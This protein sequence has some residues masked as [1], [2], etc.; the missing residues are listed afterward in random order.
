MKKFNKDKYLKMLKFKKFINT[1]SKY[2]YI[3]I[4]TMICSC[5]GMYLTYSKFF[6]NQE[7]EVIRTTV[8]NF[9]QGDVV[10]AAYINGE[11]SNS[12]PGKTDG[13]YIDKITC[14]NGTTADWDYEKWAL[15]LTNLTKKTKCNLYLKT[16]VSKVPNIIATLDT[17]G[18]C[19]TVNDDGSV[20][21][22][23][24][25]ATNGY[26]C[27]AKDAYGDSYYFRG[28]VTNNYVK[29]A[30]FYWRIVRINGDET[31]RVIYDG[32]S[33]YANGQVN[34]S[35]QIGTSYFNSSYTDNAYVGYMYGQT[36][37]SNYTATHTNTNNSTVKIYIDNWYKSK[38]KDTTYEKFIADNTFCA[39]R[40]LAKNNSGTGGSK[41]TTY[42][43]GHNFTNSSH[44]IKIILTCPQKNDAFT[45]NDITH[46]NGA[47]TY[48][49]S[50]LSMDEITLAGAWDYLVSS[51]YLFS[52][53]EWW[54]LTPSDFINDG[55]DSGTASVWRVYR[56]GYVESRGTSNEN[57]IRPVINLKPE[58]LLYGSGT[59]TDP[60][61]LITESLT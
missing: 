1:Y 39:D 31:V 54:T 35:R 12:I 59:T 37:N 30:G 17:T 33:A 6:V 28:N 43:R 45:V 52:N 55:D 15:I 48:P 25:E 13:Y 56:N 7:A 46:G 19:P 10:I 41:S 53:S 22:T 18:K 51:N 57:G 11:Y 23:G 40:S 58:T 2:I 26:L 61:R 47:L 14:D 29:F 42:Y 24:A 50:L 20:S 16:A 27:K 3:I 60:Y 34:V 9:S 4:I 5:L 38:F 8:G 44:N 49:I 32:T 21:V 36:Y